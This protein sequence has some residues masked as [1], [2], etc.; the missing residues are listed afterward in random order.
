MTLGF[1]HIIPFSV[2]PLGSLSENLTGTLRSNLKTY[3]YFAAVLWREKFL[4][5][6]FRKRLFLGL[7]SQDGLYKNEV[8]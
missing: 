4:H 2:L 3:N 5:H 1:K 8:I 6:C 7:G